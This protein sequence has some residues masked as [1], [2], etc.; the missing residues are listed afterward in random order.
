MRISPLRNP[1][2]LVYLA[3]WVLLTSISVMESSNAQ[4]TSSGITGLRIDA[5]DYNFIRPTTYIARDGAGTSILC[6]GLNDL[7]CPKETSIGVTAN[8]QP[9]SQKV[10]LGCVINLYAVNGSGKRTNAQ[11]IRIIDQYEKKND[12]SEQIDRNLVAGAGVGSAWKIP[13]VIHGGGSDTYV[14]NAFLVGRSNFEGNFSYDNF[15]FGITATTE[16]LGN[17]SARG[18]ALGADGSI[19]GIGKRGPGL[20]CQGSI[21]EDG[22]GCFTRNSMPKDTRLGVEVFLPNVLSG[23]FHGRIFR[24]QIKV[25]QIN[26]QKIRYEIEAEPVTVPILND[27]RPQNSLSSNF[28]Q[29]V[30]FRW[31]TLAHTGN[32]L[33]PGSSGGE[34]FELAS[35]YLPMIGDKASASGDFWNIKSLGGGGGSIEPNVG[36]CSGDKSVVSGIV[37]TNAMVYTASPP[38]FNWQ[39]QSLDY[40]VLSP[41]L[42]EK[43]EENLGSYDLLINAKVARCIYGFSNAP[44]RA[45]IQVL[46][47]D[48]T[49]KVATT[50]I[51]EKE[52]WIYLSA[53]GFT[54]SDPV[55]RVKL[56][57]EVEAVMVPTPTPTP[58]PSASTKPVSAKQTTITCVKG[59]TSKKVTAVKPKCPKGFKRG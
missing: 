13:G 34:A 30:D 27:V 45:E 48:G 53:N 21:A 15:Q 5:G 24:P 58:T 49:S 54:Y 6:D 25:D 8:L 37:T 20:S 1:K 55:V 9:C 41:H 22:Q 14:L 16:L 33:V 10:T 38:S 7:R 11:F 56:T 18:F 43:G 19:E 44:V 3:I 23:W 39:N 28:K 42:N 17:F 4:Y 35:L 36:V 31:G 2:V 52:D 26:A 57:Q 50:V 29:F 12:Y 32:Q 40:R 46:G 47:S 51:G 59:K